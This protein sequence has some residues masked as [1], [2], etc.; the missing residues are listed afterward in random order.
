MTER[1]YRPEDPVPETASMQIESIIAQQLELMRRQLQVLNAA[2]QGVAAEGETPLKDAVPVPKPVETPAAPAAVVEPSPAANA[3]PV[4]GPPQTALPEAVAPQATPRGIALTEA[5]TEIWLA[6]KI[7]DTASCAFNESTSFDFRGRLQP[8]ALRA[9][10]RS[11]VRRHE[12]LRTTFEPNGETQIVHPAM[13]IDV[14]LLDLS[15]S[16]ADESERALARLL[17]DEACTPFDLERGPL[18]RMRLVRRAPEHHVLVATAHHLVCDG[19]SFDVMVRDLCAAYNLACEGRPDTRPLPGMQISDY[20]RWLEGTKGSAEMQAAEAYWLGRLS[21]DLPVLELPLDRPRPPAQSYRGSCETRTLDPD[22]YA[23]VKAVGARSG[24]T[25]FVTLLSA[26]AILLYRLTGQREMV[27]GMLA[28]GQSAVGSH[29]L[30]GHCTHLLPLRLE[31]DPEDSFRRLL[32]GI[33]PLVLDAYDRQAVTFGTL[34][35][36]LKLKRDPSRPPLVSTL[37]NIDPALHGL[38]FTNL[39]MEYAANPKC[40]YQFDLAFNLTADHM[41]LITAGDYATDLFDAATI[42][43][44]LGHYQRLIEDAVQDPDRPIRRL[45]I[46]TAAERHMVLEDWNTTARA[47]PETG[48][49]GLFETQAAA[50]PD[51]IA[52]VHGDH[53]ITYRE[54]ERRANRLAR[55]LVAIGLKP[56]DLAGVYMERSIEAVTAILGV[57]KAGGAYVP[58][59]PAFPAD[60]IAFMLADSAAGI[61]LTDSLQRTD[62][63]ATPARIVQ[64]DS[65]WTTIERQP[66]RPPDGIPASPDEL[67]YVIYTSGSTGKPKGV[68]IP[69]RAVVNFLQSMAREPGMSA[70][71]RLLSVTTMS[72]DIFGLELF[73]PLTTGARVILADRDDAM[74]GQRL[75]ELIDLHA[76][77]VMQATPSTW[78]LLV[79]S[80]WSGR[81][82]LRMLCGGEALPRDLVAPLLEL[83]GELWNLYGP[84]ETTIWSTVFRVRSADEPVLIGRPIANTRTHILDDAFEPVAPGVVGELYIGGLG[85]ARGYL[86]RPELTAEKFIADPFRPGERLYRTGDLARYRADGRI[87]CLGRIDHQ[88]KLRGFRIELGEIETRLKDIE[89]IRE[90][91]A[92]LR[93]DRSGDRRLIAYYVL[94]E[95]ADATE[96]DLR[97]HLKTH[98]P[99][100]MVPQHFVRLPALPL[101]PNRKIDRK[102]LPAPLAEAGGDRAL[103]LPRSDVE[104]DIAAIWEAVL[105]C[106]PVGVSQDFFESG[107]HSLLATQVMSRINRQ[108]D[109]KL[110]LQKLFEATTIEAQAALVD[111]LRWAAAAPMPPPTAAGQR[112][113]IEL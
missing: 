66:D 34:V 69:H 90:C 40:A 62:L 13:E 73:L 33:K 8:D 4:E 58:L 70:E 103:V 56:G 53:T 88:V 95:G 98:L 64:L 35:K 47:V 25:L 67:A 99:E 59:D 94:R 111:E 83:G 91:V 104:R 108:F 55:H 71:D 60:R 9:A 107:G 57:L 26:Y 93:E 61:V 6:S 112:E 38:T 43:R 79:D 54:L 92:V 77:T 22:L 97:R 1:R 5:Q 105:R 31:L 109:I 39:E 102:A 2:W 7:G 15:A 27:I 51:A 29:D 41:R 81:S 74:D 20:A 11:I 30:V 85:L 113:V 45:A 63:P 42:R 3:S 21:R 50:T 65:D 18:L 72:F 80:G 75:G 14:P 96:S 100:Y 12:A 32:A 110:P 87:E 68:Q 86:N 52:V 23:R 49:H 17:A 76:V 84:T 46:L 78:R 106:G 16:P 19:W 48:V 10:V 36:R 24:A 101:T 37:F 82:S 89:S 28:A 44:W